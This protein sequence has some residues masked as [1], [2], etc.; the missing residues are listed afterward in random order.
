ML[1][2]NLSVSSAL[3]LFL[4]ERFAIDE[5]AIFTFGVLLYVIFKGLSKQMSL[6]VFCQSPKLQLFLWGEFLFP[7]GLD[8]AHSDSCRLRVASE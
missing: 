8:F 7:R 6:G 3:Q 5:L 4:V 1:D 2:L